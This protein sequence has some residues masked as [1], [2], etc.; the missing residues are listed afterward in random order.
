MATDSAAIN[1]STTSPSAQADVPTKPLE[2]PLSRWLT[3]DHF[4]FSSRYRSSAATNGRHFYNPLRDPV[5]NSFNKQNIQA[6]S[7]STSKL[8]WKKWVCSNNAF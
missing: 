1:Q 8:C 5:Y 7:L 4:D 2:G 6:G 3:L